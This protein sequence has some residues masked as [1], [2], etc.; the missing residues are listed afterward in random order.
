MGLIRGFEDALWF[1]GADPVRASAK[2]ARPEP[3]FSQRETEDPPSKRVLIWRAERVLF[4]GVDILIGGVN[5]D[6][7]RPETEFLGH[8]SSR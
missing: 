2:P 3:W 7:Q 4:G 5:I 8:H 6:V 1:A